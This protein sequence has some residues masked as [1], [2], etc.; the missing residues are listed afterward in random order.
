MNE[1]INIE[2]KLL[3]YLY[4]LIILKKKRYNIKIYVFSINIKTINSNYI[5]TNNK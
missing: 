5:K 2:Y 4:K 1:L 3:H